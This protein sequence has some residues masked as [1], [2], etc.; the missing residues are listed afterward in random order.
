MLEQQLEEIDANESAPLFLGSSR[1]DK[2]EERSSTLS[3]IDRA[4]ADYDNFVER[5]GRM[6]DGGFAKPR[7]I[8]S[9]QNWVNG[10]GCLSWEETEYLTHCNDLRSVV[11]S[12]DHAIVR[13]EAWVEDNVV[14]LLKK[15]PNVSTI[16]LMLVICVLNLII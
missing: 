9:L 12:E 16:V 3:E 15:L 13:F 2:N 10:N 14:R 11:P 8:R 6:L 7:D 5:N 4:L 1:D